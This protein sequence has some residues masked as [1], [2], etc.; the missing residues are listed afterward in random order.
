MPSAQSVA[1]RR[2]DDR[3]AAAARTASAAAPSTTSSGAQ[4]PS[5]QHPQRAPDQRLTVQ[6]DERLGAAHPPP[7]ARRRA[8]ARPAVRLSVDLRDGVH[9]GHRRRAGTR[10]RRTVTASPAVGAASSLTGCSPSGS[11]GQVGSMRPVGWLGHGVLLGDAGLA[12]SIPHGR[13]A[14][15]R[16]ADYRGPDAHLAGRLA[17]RRRTTTT[18]AAL[19]RLRPDLAV[20]PP[21]DLTVLATR[22]GDAGVGA[23]RL[24][25]PRHGHPGRA[26]GAG[27]RRRR[28]GAR[29][30]WPSCAGCSGPTC[31]PPADRCGPGGPARAGDR[32]GPRQRAVAGAR[33][34]RRR[35]ALPRWAGPPGRRAGR[36]PRAAR[37]AG[38]GRPRGAPGARR[39][40]RRVRRSGAAGPGRT[41]TA[42]SGGCSPRGCCCGS[43]PRPSSCR[44]RS[45]WRCAATGRSGRCRPS[46]R[47]GRRPRPRG[48]RRRP[49][50]G[51]G[52][53]RAAAPGRA[54]AGV[55]GP[56]PAAGAALGRAGRAR[57]APRGQGDG[58]RRAD[59][60]AA[61]SSW[62]W[63]PT[64]SPRP[65]ASRRSGCPPPRSTCGPPAARSTRWSLLARSWLELPRLPGLV[66]RKDDAGKADRRAVRRRAPAAGPARPAPRARRAGRAAARHRA[67]LGR[68]A[69]RAAGLAGPPP[70]RP[71]ARRGRRLGARRGHRARGRR[72]GRALRAR[73]GAARRPRPAR[74]RAARRCCP[75]PVDHVLLQADLTAVAPGP[76][77]PGLAAELELVAD[78]ESAGGATVYRFTEAIRAPRPRRRAHRRRPARAARHALGHARCRR[79]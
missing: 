55:L 22:A 10:R 45:G 12:C 29:A 56:H 9:V 76:L 1:P 59:G 74:R 70:R 5:A 52:R 47:R 30:R 48:G 44:G 36:R 40:G 2:C 35:A 78:V 65:T 66:G 63:R 15:P 24:R 73:P 53:A 19:L 49:H 77:E 4:P 54:A 8:A 26:G 3:R 13:A 71:A 68:G 7:G 6:L 37:A 51:R 75:T 60:R 46:P 43:T 21:A 67:R 28:A 27:R 25:R 17:A 69:G 79:G 50:R 16:C 39:A 62:R 32:L 11:S 42:R 34:P 61:R 20:P 57:A 33:G 58:R 38:R 18:L 14:S 23:P 41:R 64:W 72:P 31:P